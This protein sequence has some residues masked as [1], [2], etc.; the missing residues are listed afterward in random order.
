MKI[1]LVG[2]GGYARLY[3]QLMLENKDP[4]LKLEGIV[5]KYFD[6][7]PLKEEIEK[8]NIPVYETMEEFYEKHEADLAV[9]ST[10]P[11]LHKEQC[12]LALENG[13]Y[14]LCEKPVAPTVSE[15]EEMLEAEKKYG[16]FIAIGYQWSYSD[17]I[18]S[19]KKD[20]LDGKLGKALSFKT[21]ISWPR[22]KA[23]Y[24]RGGGWG[25]RISK[26]GITILDS[27]ASNACAHYIHNMLF[28]LG[29]DMDSSAA[30]K[31]LEAECLRANDIENFD[32][33][34]IKMH[35]PGGAE[36]FFAASHAAEKELHP[37][38]VYTFENAVVSFPQGDK[39][40]IT[41]HFADG[42]EKNYGDPF[43]NDMKK[44]HDAVK[45]VREGTKPVCTVKTA[46]EHTKLIGNIYENVKI[47]DFPEDMKRLQDN[48]VYVEGL[49]EK[50]CKA[51][52]DCAMFSEL[53]YDFIRI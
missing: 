43:Q 49:F 17:A 14:V 5:E 50:L 6:T 40:L 35:M 22:D 45:A 16:K 41:A 34:T 13:S 47:A 15:A 26:D 4:D 9:I 29:R 20:I 51:Y 12:I 48:R 37:Q 31:R 11:F 36:L 46:M 19:L 33:C 2:A 3:V 25:G 39:S 1:L 24:A 27:I 30:P 28:L 21:I 53:G 10:P 8:A 38:F 42:S 7:C 52:E 44:F 18:Q 23:Y 32:T